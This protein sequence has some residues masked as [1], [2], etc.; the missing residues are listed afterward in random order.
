MKIK[1]HISIAGRKIGQGHPVFIVAEISAN[2][3]NDF[4]RAVK[5]I[6]EA[7]RCGADAV[8]FQTYTPDTLTLDHKS[9]YFKLKNTKW[10]GQYLY[11][12]YE[13]AYTP[14]HWF[15]KLKRIAEDLGLVFFSTSFDKTSVDFLEA[16]RVPVHKIASFELIDLPLIEYAA[17]AKKPLI[18][19]TGM[20]AVSEITDAVDAAD[21]CG[22]RGVIL[23][24]CVSSYPA[25]PEEMNLRTIPDMKRRFDRIVGLS[26]HTMGIDASVI[27][28]ALGAG[29]I[30]KHFT[31]SR[32]EKGPDSFFSIEPRELKDLIHKI[33]A[34]ED[35]L[36]RVS[37]RPTKGES[38]LIRFRRSLFA[39][40]DIKK[41]AVFMECNV[42]SIRP[43][44]G[45]HPKHLTEIY[46]R[47]AKR[48]IK[49]GT[50]LNWDLV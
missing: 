15:A 27:A 1:N 50:P 19:S 30:E 3:Q 43:G 17:R 35:I 8:K 32:S 38:K 49:R 31:L 12:L 16:L 11:Q 28:V 20:A 39:V 22:A 7:K 42:R 26:D 18:L 46:G 34:A 33:R 37:Y 48:D 13:R 45:L 5:L 41:G 36:G 44:C 14:W 21:K 25:K 47:R 40:E 9:R 10:R 6:K 2:H 23:L 4:G 29:M 24:K